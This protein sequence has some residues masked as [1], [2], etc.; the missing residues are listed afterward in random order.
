MYKEFV[1]L[2][3]FLGVCCTPWYSYA[4]EEQEIQEEES[5]E[6][7]LEE[8]SD[9]FQENFFEGLKQKGIQNYDRAINYL[10]ECKRLQP[11]NE[12]VTHELAKLYFLDKNYIESLDYAVDAVSKKPDNYWYLYTLITSLKA[13]GNNLSSVEKDIPMQHMILRENLA[14]IYYG[15]DNYDEALKLVGSLEPSKSVSILGQKIKDA[16]AIKQR[17]STSVSFTSATIANNKAVNAMESYKAR[18]RGLLMM[19]SGNAMLLRV[20]ED[21][22]ENY[23]AQPYFY[24][25]NGYA[26]NKNG[27]YRDAIN[28]LETALDYMVSDISLANKIY[29]E[30]SIAYNAISNPSKANMYLRKV[31][32]GF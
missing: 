15:Q 4:Q 12:A 24:Y 14:K 13:Q 18:I 21:A 7:F 27:K 1:L 26:L 23:P 5:A 8:Y 19:T 10:L 25:A 2:L 30:L 17:N 3:L 29:T 28:V 31:K 32:P 6:V 11:D 9:E 22:L 16:I 20:S